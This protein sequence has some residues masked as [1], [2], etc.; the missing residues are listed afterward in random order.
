MNCTVYVYCVCSFFLWLS[1]SVLEHL[2]HLNMPL[3]INL[4]VTHFKII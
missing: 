3:A 4:N 1:L 2:K